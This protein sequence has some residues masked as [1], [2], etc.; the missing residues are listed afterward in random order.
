MTYSDLVTLLMVFFV[1]LYTLTPG[2]DTKRFQ[3]FLIQFQGERSVL[4]AQSIVIQRDMVTSVQ[5]RQEAQLQSLQDFIEDNE[6]RDQ[7]DVELTPEGIRISLSESITFPSGSAD[8]IPGARDII[9]SIAALL[10]EDIREVE[11]QGHTDDVPIGAS[12]RFRSNW[13]LGAARAVTVVHVLIDES[14]LSAEQFKGS[15]FSEYR[16]LRP[17]DGAENRSRNRRVEIYVRYTELMQTILQGNE[18]PI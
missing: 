16:P 17:N 14:P 11:V 12:S 2:V 3:Q 4:D 10:K 8:L 18:F 7:V 1:V 6:I 13:D 9:A 5:E 15:T